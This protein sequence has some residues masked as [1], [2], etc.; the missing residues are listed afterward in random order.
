[1]DI[2]FLINRGKEK[3]RT[4]PRRLVLYLIIFIFLNVI[5][6]VLFN[7]AL[8]PLYK[9]N[10][11]TV[12]I[13]KFIITSAVL[14]I[15]YSIIIS[16]KKLII[17]FFALQ[18]VYIIINIAYYSYYHNYLHIF[19][20]VKLFFEGFDLV[21]Y[22]QIPLST[23]MLVV[24]IDLP[25]FIILINK[26]SSIKHLHANR[27]ARIIRVSLIAALLLFLVM[28]ERWNYSKGA[29]IAHYFDDTRHTRPGE[30]AIIKRYGLLVNSIVY[31]MK[32][33]QDNDLIKLLDN[34]P[35][36]TSAGREKDQKPDIILI[37]AEAM[38]AHAVKAKY[39]GRHIMPFLGSIKD[40][41]IYYPY[42]LAYHKGGGTSDCEFS[43]INSVEPLDHFPGIK[44]RY[45]SY[46][47]S[48]IRFLKKNGYSSY[49]FHGNRGDYFNRIIAFNKMGFI[50]F[51]DILKM[52]LT[53]SGWGAPDEDLFDYI[54]KAALSHKKPVYYHIITMSSH[55][56]FTTVSD[57]YTDPYF[58]TVKKKSARDYFNSMAYLDKQIE[59]FIKDIKHDNTYIFIYGDH[60]SCASTI[61]GIYSQSKYKRGADAFE[62]VPLLI[63]TPEKRGYTEKRLAA[64]FLDLG[65]TILEAAGVPYE[66]RTKGENLLSYPIKDND[67]PF[68]SKNYKRSELYKMGLSTFK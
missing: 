5:K 27:P 49:A 50:D 48:F 1:M 13:Y 44:L 53:E 41:S 65:I 51:Y 29:S 15:I 20:S 2:S 34:G 22:M 21:K 23:S 25:L 66:I 30:I 54:S 24:F 37:Q 58:E 33:S 46:E 40:A 4:L 31:M 59:K 14:F 10:I 61:P 6:V 64:S 11:I 56:P 16:N 9:D 12:L 19:L 38:D 67:I 28:V 60:A 18:C 62:F 45:Y 7:M 42:V 36:H 8:L 63:I 17:F 47:N 52:E 32:Y 55:I 57:Y 35:L 43:I 26:H 3:L 68:K 39:N